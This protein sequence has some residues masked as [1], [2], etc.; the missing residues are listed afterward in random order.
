MGSLP[1]DTPYSGILAKS[2]F[3][4]S[5]VGGCLVLLCYD[6]HAHYFLLSF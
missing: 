3:G 1:V 5:V 4:F 2:T 6:S